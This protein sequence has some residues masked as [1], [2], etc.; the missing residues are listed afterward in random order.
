MP[1]TNQGD[2]VSNGTSPKTL[3]IQLRGAPGFPEFD[4]LAAL[5]LFPINKR[6]CIHTDSGHLPPKNVLDFQ[7]LGGGR[8]IIFWLG[9]LCRWFE[10]QPPPSMGL[11]GSVYPLRRWEFSPLRLGSPETF[12]AKLEQAQNDLGI[13][14][15]EQIPIQS[16]GQELFFLVGGWSLGG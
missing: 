6:Q 11:K 10:I 9:S 3:T 8:N 14:S 15:V 4:G 16:L 12:E 2:G 1:L 7:E 13:P 5:F